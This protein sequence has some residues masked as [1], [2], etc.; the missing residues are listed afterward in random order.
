VIETRIEND[1]VDLYDGSSGMYRRTIRPGGTP[2]DV[3]VEGDEIAITL[4]NGNVD[5]YS[6]NGIYR[7]TMTR[8]QDDTVARRVDLDPSARSPEL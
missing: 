4:Q 1:Q 5:F 8:D 2:T 7:R 3:E 6:T